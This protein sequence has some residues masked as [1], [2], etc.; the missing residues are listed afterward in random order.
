M[1]LQAVTSSNINSIGYSPE[2]RTLAVK[3]NHGGTYHYAGVP[4][5]VWNGMKS[6]ESVGKYFADHVKG[7]YPGQQQEVAPT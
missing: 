7:K 5:E 2:G 1:E 4:P 6:A 3:F